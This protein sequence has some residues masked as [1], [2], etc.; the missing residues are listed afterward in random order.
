MPMILRPLCR[1]RIFQS[2]MSR[3]ID[4]YMREA[5]GL[6]D[7]VKRH[8]PFL[9]ETFASKADV[10]SEPIPNSPA[11]PISG[12]SRSTRPKVNRDPVNQAL[13]K[14]G[15]PFLHYRKEDPRRA[16]DRAAVRRLHSDRR[17]MAKPRLDALY[18]VPGF[19]Q[20]PSGIQQQQVHATIS[21]GPRER[22]SSVMMQNPNIIRDAVKVR[23]IS[24][25]KE[26]SE[27]ASDPP[28]SF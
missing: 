26:M 6:I 20:T 3:A 23:L 24:W 8:T 17:R 21:H 12:L 5:H 19:A 25:R 10:W 22:P 18:A 15:A 4:P 14:L 16:A 7:T 28:R 27:P 9:S 1:I 13:L 11:F 2:Q